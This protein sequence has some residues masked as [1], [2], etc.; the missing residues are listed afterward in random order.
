SVDDE[1]WVQGQPTSH[2]VGRLL[3]DEIRRYEVDEWGDS[4]WDVADS[5]SA[6]LEGA[7]ASL[8]DVEGRFREDFNPISDPI[9][10]LYRFELHEDF[11]NWRLAVLDAFCR[12]FGSTAVVLAQYHTTWLSLAEFEQI[13][14]RLD[15]SSVAPLT[16]SFADNNRMN[17]FMVRDNELQSNY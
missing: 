17:R 16:E 10:Y 4:A 7:F 11:S 1:D 2:V 13:G 14:F 8:L 9:V 15:G 12:Q 5:N 6:G 3:A